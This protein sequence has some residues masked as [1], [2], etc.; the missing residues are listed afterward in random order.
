MDN[1]M[2]SI[3]GITVLAGIM[4]LAMS[5]GPVGDDKKGPDRP[6]IKRLSNF[7]GN[8]FPGFAEFRV[9]EFEYDDF[10]NILPKGEP[11]E[12]LLNVNYITSAYRYEDG[13]KTD[14]S[15]IVF[16]NYSEVAIFVRQEYDDVVSSIRKAAEAQVK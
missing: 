1:V 4:M 2:K 16:V 6:V 3:L 8:H 12:I 10:H 7:R 5:L 14:Y 11:Y 13:K 15:T 9:Q